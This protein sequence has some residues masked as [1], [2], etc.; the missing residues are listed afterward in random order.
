V[1]AAE[2]CVHLD[3]LVFALGILVHM[4]SASGQSSRQGQRSKQAGRVS[5]RGSHHGN[6]P[7]A[8][9]YA[10][11]WKKVPEKCTAGLPRVRKHLMTEGDGGFNPCIERRR[12]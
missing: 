8:K 1:D 6:R 7:L 5:N 10:A 9:L 11:G 12:E 4:D 3:V 2:R